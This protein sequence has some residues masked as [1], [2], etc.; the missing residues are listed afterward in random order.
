MGSDKKVALFCILVASFVMASHASLQQD[1]QE[2]ADQLTNL[3]SCIPFV[4]GTAEKPTAECCQDTQKVKANKPKCLCVL[5]KESTDPS[6]GLPVNTTLALQMPSACNI[7]AKVSDCPSILNLLPDSPDAKIFKEATGSDSSTT[8]SYT[9]SA[10]SS[11]SA[12]SGSSSSSPDSSSNSDSKTTSSSNNGAK[13]KLFG[14]W[15][16]MAFVAWLLI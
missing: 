16:I 15:I 2:C 7:D 5:I 1:E 11:A 10:P 4:S 6:M 14:G 13:K 9:D 12:S 8:S 3:A